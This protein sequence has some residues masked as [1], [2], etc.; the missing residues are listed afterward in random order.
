MPFPNRAAV[1]T[2]KGS[3]LEPLLTMPDMAMDGAEIRT[4]SNGGKPEVRIGEGAL[5]PEKEYRVAVEDYRT[6]YMP[7]LKGAPVE[8][9]DD[10]RDLVARW[11]QRGANARA[12][13]PS[14]GARAL[15]PL[16][17]GLPAPGA[18]SP[19]VLT[20]GVP[21]VIKSTNLALPR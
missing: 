10:I 12:A 8:T 4:L 15:R 3:A 20:P 16:G 7:G 1:A 11:A 6:T 14:E 2:V 5:D 13:R 17:L 18:A 9:R 21:S 19:T